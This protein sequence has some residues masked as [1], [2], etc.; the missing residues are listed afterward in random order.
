M[1]V[2]TVR[3]LKFHGGVAKEDLNQ[4]DVER[5]SAGWKNLTAHVENIQNTFAIPTVVAI[6]RFLTDTQE[7]LDVVKAHCEAIGAQAVLADVWAHGGKGAIDLA[8]AVM[9]AVQAPNDG[10]HLLYPD[11]MPLREKDHDHR[12]DHL[13]RGRRGL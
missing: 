8:K 9:Q 5:S 12:Q 1:I 11:E 3:A 10:P 6:N 13:R 2:A 4:P 7:E